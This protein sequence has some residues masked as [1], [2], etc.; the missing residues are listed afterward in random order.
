[1]FAADDSCLGATSRWDMRQM[2]RMPADICWMRWCSEQWS[3]VNWD[4][5]VR[6]RRP[7]SEKARKLMRHVL[8]LLCSCWCL[9]D[10][11]IRARMLSV[12][13]SQANLIATLRG[14]RIENGQELL[15]AASYKQKRSHFQ[16]AREEAIQQWL[17]V[18]KAVV[19]GVRSLSFCATLFH[20]GVCTASQECF[21]LGDARGY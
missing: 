6:C 10:A 1:M 17:W 20:S 4:T 16:I 18:R 5:L 19:G 12:Q 14:M 15:Q 3:L 21:P 9:S 8:S 2:R 13:R 7:N 11:I